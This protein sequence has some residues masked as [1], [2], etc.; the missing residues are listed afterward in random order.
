MNATLNRNIADRDAFLDRAYGLYEEF[1]ASLDVACKPGCSHCCTRDVTVT[2]LEAYRVVKALK[3]NGNY[4]LI[5]KVLKEDKCRFQPM[6]TTN[7]LAHLCASDGEIPTEDHPVS[8]DPCPLLDH[9]L[10]SIYPHRP[11]GCRCFVSARN[12]REHQFADVDPF[13]LTVNTVFLQF[14]EQMD[15]PGL[16]GNFSDVLRFLDSESHREVYEGGQLAGLP[17]GLVF[18]RSIPVLMVPPEHRDQIKTLLT[19]LANLA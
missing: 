16:Y 5:Q 6:M 9:G 15:T 18:N 7:Q 10:C 8:Q 19:R 3:K 13:V 14:I 11:F 17:Q 1:S 2:T 4:T 12:C